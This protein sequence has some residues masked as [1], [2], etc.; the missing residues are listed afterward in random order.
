MKKI[1]A[2][3]LCITMLIPCAMFNTFAQDS[4]SVESGKVLYDQQ[5]GENFV[6]KDFADAGMTTIANSTNNE[7]EIVDGILSSKVASGKKSTVVTLP[8]VVPD[9]KTY[10][11]EVEFRYKMNKSNAERDGAGLYVGFDYKNNEES[12][13]NGKAGMYYTLTKM[14]DGTTANSYSS[15]NMKFD[16]PTD[17]SALAAVMKAW[18]IGDNGYGATV[19]MTISVEDD[20][21]RKIT[22][23]CGGNY[24][25]S[26]SVISDYKEKKLNS[27]ILYL[28][29]QQAGL[30]IFSVRVVEGVDYANVTNAGVQPGLTDAKARLVA[31]IDGSKFA[32]AGFKV[33]LSYTDN[34]DSSS[35]VAVTTDA[36]DM[37]AHYAYSSLAADGVIGAI[38]PQK[39]GNYLIAIVIDGIPDYVTDLK[40][41]FT[42][43]AVTADGETYI[44][45]QFVYDFATQTVTVQ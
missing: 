25:E 30:D 22:L 35:P 1:L 8:D 6:G 38:T 5:F 45:L 24:F 39:D 19:K 32:A 34:T 13:H 26:T 9:H 3:I 17:T 43:Y 27:D 14:S 28:W 10:T 21:L 41:T 20:Y 44:G 7:N 4:G 2:F 40:V 11:V 16:E 23:S 15:A 29:N 18:Y 37:T 36:K 12:T 42:P 33:S 31:E